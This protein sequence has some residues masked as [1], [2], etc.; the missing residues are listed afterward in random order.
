MIKVFAGFAA[1]A[2]VAPVSVVAIAAVY[3]LEVLVA[4][5]QAYVFTILTCIYLK[6][7]LHPA[8]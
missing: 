8:H 7:A 6:D 3:G 4:G 5:I 1:I 2:A